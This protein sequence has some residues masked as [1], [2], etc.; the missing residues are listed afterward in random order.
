[1]SIFILL[2]ELCFYLLY[3][4]IVVMKHF[5]EETTGIPYQFR[6]CNVEWTFQVINQYPIVTLIPIAVVMWLV[7]ILMLFSL[8]STYLS[9]RYYGYSLERRA[10]AKYVIWWC[11]QAGLLLLCCI[12]YFQII[13]L[14]LIP[15]FIF[16][17]WILFCVESRKLDKTILAVLFEIRNFENDP[18]RYKA[19]YS[20]HRTYRIFITIEIILLLIVITLLSYGS[21]DYL[22]DVVLRDPCYFEKVYNITIPHLSNNTTEQVYLAL[23]DALLYGN[24]TFMVVYLLVI[25]FYLCFIIIPFAINVLYKRM[26]TNRYLIHLNREAFLPLLNN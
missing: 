3:P 20:S 7:T 2:L 17:D 5:I 22:L 24:F 13:S 16:I 4:L 19:L 1:M 14:L 8:L 26:Y 21:F 18:F 10:I 9:R 23:K 11:T 25:F 15:L 6:A 12:T